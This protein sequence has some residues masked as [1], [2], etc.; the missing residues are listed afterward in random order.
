MLPGLQIFDLHEPSKCKIL[1][2]IGKDFEDC[3]PKPISKYH[4]SECTSE[5]NDH[6]LIVYLENALCRGTQVEYEDISRMLLHR[7]SKVRRISLMLHYRNFPDIIPPSFQDDPDHSVRAV[8][9]S[10]RWN[11]RISSLI[12]Q[13]EDENPD[14]RIAALHQLMRFSEDEKYKIKI[15]RSVCHR[16]HDRELTIRVFVSRAIGEFKDLS[17]EV[18]EKLL[19]KQVTSLDD[20]KLCGA[21]IYGVEDEYSDVRRNT[22]SSVYSL[23]TP[24]IVSRAFDF[25][26]DSL[27]DEDGDLRELSTLCLKKMSIKYT[28]VIDREIVRQ[29]CES[30]KERRSKVKANILSLLANLKY[31][32]VEIFDIL[33]SHMDVNVRSRDVFR[34]IRKIVSRNRK[35]FFANMDRFYKHT[36]I[37]QVES[38]LEDTFYI[39]RLVVLRELKKANPGIRMSE[40]IENHFLFLE[41][42]ECSEPDGC[43]GGYVFFRDILH[44]FLEELDGGEQREK[45]YRRLFRRMKKENDHRY[46]FIYYIYKGMA[47]L[48]RKGKSNILQRIPFLFANTGF[49]PSMA[50]NT[51]NIAEYIRSL[52]FGSIRFLKY[53]V[54]VPS[55]VKVCG[56]M[57]VRF[58]ASLLFEKDHQDVH[59][60]VWSSDKTPIYFKARKTIEVCILE[61]VSSI[62]CSVVK[63]H[64]GQD[65]PLSHTKA[66]SIERK[67]PRKDLIPGIDLY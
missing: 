5:C 37:A 51:K 60:K 38:S 61:D 30:L 32:D 44:Q 8:Y 52:D 12:K 66:I 35:L 65:I 63:L 29:I 17:D 55:R 24:G 36:S 2:T 39:A 11:L 4:S 48:L 67:K 27:N 45:N 16:I 54:D 46:W 23:V 57:P 7:N 43:G 21:L 9:L 50:N 56:R 6:H 58:S 59:L 15:L 1:N 42:M 28:L 10:Q 41:I 31:E 33:V 26:V 19:S 22:I 13:A 3:S 25:I 47:E 18:V 34:C 49:D 53:D 64:S 40:V 20:Q 62:Y 14:V